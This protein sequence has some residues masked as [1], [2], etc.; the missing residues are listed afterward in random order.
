MLPISWTYKPP[1]NAAAASD[2]LIYQLNLAQAAMEKNPEGSLIKSP[3][4]D[5]FL[6]FQDQFFSILCK[7]FFSFSP[8]IDS[9]FLTAPKRQIQGDAG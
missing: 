4:I 2:T 7:N 9:K 3:M 1:S 8:H 5:L 6:H